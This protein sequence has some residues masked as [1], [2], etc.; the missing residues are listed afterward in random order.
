MDGKELSEWM[1]NQRRQEGWPPQGQGVR[2]PGSPLAST[3]PLVPE[4]PRVQVVNPL[5]SMY[6]HFQHPMFDPFERQFRVQP[7]D[8]FFDPDRSPSNPFTFSIGGFKAAK[9]QFLVVLG[10]RFSAAKFGLTSGDT[11]P[12]EDGRMGLLWAFDLDVDG[13]RDRQCQYEID[14][15][16]IS[17]TRAAFELVAG[18]N[19]SRTQQAAYFDKNAANSFAITAGPGKSA[20][21]FQSQHF[22]PQAPAFTIMVRPNQTIQGSCIIFRPLEVPLAYVQFDVSGYILPPNLVERFQREVQP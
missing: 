15:V 11:V 6:E 3:N 22:G 20:L 2:G 21:P 18:T 7:T 16:P 17:T 5:G 13:R 9:D 8:A 10:Y 1:Q 12:L 19:G 14:P 4:A